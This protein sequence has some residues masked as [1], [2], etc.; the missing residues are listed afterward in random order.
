M[1]RYFTKSTF[2]HTAYLV[3]FSLIF[4]TVLNAQGLTNPL[5]FNSLSQFLEAILSAVITIAFPIIVLMFV[6]S[7]FLFITAQGNEQK[8]TQ[9]R[10]VLL[11][12][13]VGALLILGAQVLS[14]A[15]QGT[16]DEIRGAIP[17]LHRTV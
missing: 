1:Y 12:T 6:Y 2:F 5:Q 4:P 7:G 17:S 11:W 9:F 3:A 10:R 8:L 13:I 14:S 15:I 16:V